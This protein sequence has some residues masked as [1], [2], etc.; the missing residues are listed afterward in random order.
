MRQDRDPNDPTAGR[1][2][3]HR[4]TAEGFARVHASPKATAIV[5]FGDGSFLDANTAFVDISGFERSELLDHDLRDLGVFPDVR[6]RE[7][8]LRELEDCGEV[9]AWR[10]RLRRRD[11]VVRDILFSA[12]LLEVAGRPA[13]LARVRDVTVSGDTDTDS[14][15]DRAG[16]DEGEGPG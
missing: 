2:A 1:R 13:I 7:A 10:S 4:L 6:H 12:Q 14:V 5:S 11:G 3:T 16:S 15:T 8:M 9:R